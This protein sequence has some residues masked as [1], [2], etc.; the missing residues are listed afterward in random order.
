[1][2][3]P[4]TADMFWLWRETIFSPGFPPRRRKRLSIRNAYGTSLWQPG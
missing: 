2:G 3:V 1:L 4:G